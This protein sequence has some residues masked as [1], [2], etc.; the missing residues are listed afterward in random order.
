MLIAR[1]FPVVHV[2]IQNKE[3]AVK[4]HTKGHVITVPEDIQQLANVVLPHC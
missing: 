1:A 2:Y 3:E 4:E